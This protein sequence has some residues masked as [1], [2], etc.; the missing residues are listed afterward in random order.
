MLIVE[1]KVMI[2]DRLLNE[3]ESTAQNRYISEIRI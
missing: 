3:A 1:N 2:T